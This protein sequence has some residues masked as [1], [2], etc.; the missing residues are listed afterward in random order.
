MAIESSSVTE[1]Q[2]AGAPCWVELSTGDE[3]RALEFYA[4]LFGWEYRIT[5]DSTVMTGRYAIGHRDGFAVAGLF[6]TDRPSGWMPHIAVTDTVSGAE[7]VGLCGG[8]VELGPIDFPRYDSMVYARDPLGAP[9]VLRSP[10]AGW[11]FTTGSPGTFASADLNTRDG[12][13]ADEFYCRMFGFVSIQLGDGRDID[14]A[15]WQLDGQPVLYRYVMGPEYAP[16]TPAHWMIYFVADPLEGTDATAVRTLGLGGTIAV[17]PYDSPL[18][19][20]AILVDP[21][22]ATFAVIDPM[23]SPEKRRAPVEDPDAD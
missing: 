10:P 1:V 7:R 20:V 11:L 17:E 15:E 16:T 13:T 6:Q 18:G 21:G 19:R 12:F 4:G 22:G 3:Q 5:P 2:P 8:N 9:V 23:D 14:Y